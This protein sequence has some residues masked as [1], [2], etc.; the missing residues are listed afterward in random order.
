MIALLDKH[1]IDLLPLRRESQTARAQPFGQVVLNF[2]MAGC[3]HGWKQS[4]APA[5]QVKI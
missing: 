2:V 4:S 5:G 1:V 3:P